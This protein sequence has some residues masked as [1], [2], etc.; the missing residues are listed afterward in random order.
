MVGVW[1]HNIWVSEYSC[2]Q[3]LWS[4]AFCICIKYMYIGRFQKFSTGVWD[5]L[6]YLFLLF[7]E[8][9]THNFFYGLD[10]NSA[11]RRMCFRNQKEVLPQLEGCASAT[12]RMCFRNQKEVLPQLEGN[13]SATRWM[14][15]PN[16]KDVLPPLEG[17]ASATAYTHLLKDMLLRNFISAIPQS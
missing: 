11:T 13:A 2:L 4:V 7:A 17:C 9:S 1:D 8:V 15:F 5:S 12:R 6:L 3:V 10:R 16:Q 14:C